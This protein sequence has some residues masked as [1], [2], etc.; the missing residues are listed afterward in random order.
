MTD[1]TKTRSD[2]PALRQIKNNKPPLYF[3]SACTSLKPQSVIDAVTRYYTEHTGCAGRSDHW[4]AEKTQQT[5]DETRALVG[6]YLNTKKTEEIIFTA[7]TTA[8]INLLAYQLNQKGGVVITSD[9]EH[10][11]NFLPWLRLAQQEKI[12]LEII[13]TTLPNGQTDMAR[14]EDCLKKHAD[15]TGFKLLTIHHVSNLDG[16]VQDIVKLSTLAHTYGFF[17]HLDAAQSAP[18]MKIDV[19]GN[20][21][22][23]LSFS[24]HKALGPSG[25]GVLYGKEE[26]L[27]TFEP[28][29]IGGGTPLDVNYDSF[30]L[31]YTPQRFE[32]GIQH[33][34]GIT[35]LGEAMT[36]LTDLYETE[37]VLSHAL[38]L[39]TYLT[40]QLT[41][42]SDRIHIIGS[43]E[44][45]NRPT[46]LSFTLDGM[47]HQQVAHLLNER[48]N[49]M[50]RAGRHCVHAYCNAN[51][52][53]GTV[54]VSF[55][56][57][58]TEKECAVF[59][60]TL[61]EIVRI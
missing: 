16:S 49:I 39:N 18:H 1:L 38:H 22:D 24:G 19:Q 50:V 37:D 54:R 34:A 8:A 41:Q 28:I 51:N 2:F 32:A 27:A 60:D 15:N 4:F 36:Y 26:L 44:A 3:D 30:Q 17:I 9:K 55:H 33:Y 52:I 47:H 14:L 57:Y 25:T 23:F 10:N 35:G 11:S 56:V 21:I 43:A 20:N 48:A 40:Q 7:N 12:A 58:N 31:A 5:V 13:P 29:T 61:S 42:I 46:I 53:A 6:D 59:V 45:K